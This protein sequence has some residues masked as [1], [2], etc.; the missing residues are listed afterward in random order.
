MKHATNYRKQYEKL[1]KIKIPKGYEI[2]HINLNHEDNKIENLVMLPRKLHQE[3]HEL[4]RN[5]EYFNNIEIRLKSIIDS[6]NKSNEF[7]IEQLNKLLKVYEEC[8]KY[9]CYR[10]YLRGI[11]PNIYEIEVQI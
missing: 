6:G 8:C 9:V 5:I 7:K 11:I 4:I 3:Y 1:C 2:H 10:D